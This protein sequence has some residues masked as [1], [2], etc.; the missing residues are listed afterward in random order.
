MP[1]G[2]EGV[3]SSN[4]VGN[5]H[6]VHRVIDRF[7]YLEMLNKKFKIRDKMLGLKDNLIFQ[8]NNHPKHIKYMLY[9]V[10]KWL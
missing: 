4:W 3:N 10:S 9:H 2:S 1:E 7:V 8:Q 5:L 6:I